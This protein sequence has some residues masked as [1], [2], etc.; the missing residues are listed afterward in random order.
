MAKG[1]EAM[2]PHVRFQTY[3]LRYNQMKWI[4]LDAL[5]KHWERA[6]IDAELVDEGHVPHQDEERRGVHDRAARRAR[7]RWTRRIRRGWSSTSRSW[8]AR[9]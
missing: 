1:R 4:T 2:P 7:R 9:R 3:T 6:E 5:E 8:S